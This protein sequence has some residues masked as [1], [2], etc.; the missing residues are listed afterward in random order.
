MTDF[1]TK[2][3]KKPILPVMA[4]IQLSYSNKIEGPTLP[5]D[6][7]YVYTIVA[8]RKLYINLTSLV[9]FHVYQLSTFIN[10]SRKTFLFYILIFIQT[11][12]FINTFE[13]Q[14]C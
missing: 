5:H 8:T 11:M 10:R 7:F 12:N 13:L 1:P 9:Y 4:V 3:G 6:R 14:V 2:F